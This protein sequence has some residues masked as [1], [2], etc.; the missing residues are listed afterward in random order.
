MLINILCAASHVLCTKILGW[1]FVGERPPEK[2]VML[3]GAPHTSNLDYFLTLALIHHW[4]LPLRYLV[5]NNAFKGPLAPILKS[6]GG[7]PVDRSKSNQLV[8]SMVETIKAQDEIAMG[9]L[10]EGTRKYVEYWKS[11]FYFIAV[12]AE[13]PIYPVLVDGAE[14]TILMGPKMV[15]S[16]DLEGDVALLADFFGDTKGVKPEKSG[17]VRV[18]P[19]EERKGRLA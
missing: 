14:K 10:P 2:K 1:K 12:G 18:R 17:P 11:G 9:V 15:P 8:D 19:R 5:K 16:G 4:Q 3:L 7:I 13:I 6:L